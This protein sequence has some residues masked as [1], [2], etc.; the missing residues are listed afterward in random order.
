M[1]EISVQSMNST[2]TESSVRSLFE[3]YGKVERVKIVSRA[4][5]KMSNAQHAI[6]SLQGSQ[7]DGQSLT[8]SKWLE[9]QSWRQMIEGVDP[10]WDMKSMVVWGLNPASTESSVHSLFKRCGIVDKLLIMKEATVVMSDANEAQRAIDSLLDRFQ[11][12]RQQ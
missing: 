9:A 11:R 4:F 1:K 7:L 3:P 5:V 6:D 12:L 8:I 2:H 10:A